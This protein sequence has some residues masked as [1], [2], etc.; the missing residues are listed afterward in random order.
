MLLLQVFGQTYMGSG[1]GTALFDDLK[2][3]AQAG[4]HDVDFA[5]STP[6]RELNGTGVSGS[7][8]VQSSE[9]GP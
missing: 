7:N 2:L 6:F 5:A 8:W 4:W 3:R 1:N 9:G